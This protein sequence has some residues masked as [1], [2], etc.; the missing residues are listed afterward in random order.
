[1]RKAAYLWLQ[2]KRWFDIRF[3]AIVIC[4]SRDSSA[5]ITCYEGIDRGAC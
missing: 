4:I 2:D 5:Q 3:D 1:M